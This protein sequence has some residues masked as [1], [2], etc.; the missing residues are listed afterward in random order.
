MKKLN[1]FFLG[2][3]IRLP[4]PIFFVIASEANQSAELFYI[5]N[6]KKG[7]PLKS[8]CD[9]FNENSNCKTKLYISF[10]IFKMIW[11][12]SSISSKL[13]VKGGE[14]RIYSFLYNCQN[15]IKP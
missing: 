9:Y 11:Q 2:S 14:M 1:D 8:G 15:T 10:K 7:F 3:L 5:R 12:P 13:I 4:L 6:N